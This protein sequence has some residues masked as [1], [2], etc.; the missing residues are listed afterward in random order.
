MNKIAERTEQCSGKAV[1]TPP[2]YFS[3]RTVHTLKP[4][5]IAGQTTHPSTKLTKEKD[6]ASYRSSNGED[7]QMKS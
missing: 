5:Q 3:E 2:K 1:V 6:Y 4:N 7:H